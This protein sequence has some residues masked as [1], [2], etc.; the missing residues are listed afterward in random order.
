VHAVIRTFIIYHYLFTHY[1]SASRRCHGFRR[2]CQQRVRV[3]E[4]NVAWTSRPSNLQLATL[5]PPAHFFVHTPTATHP[6]PVLIFTF[7]SRLF[8]RRLSTIQHVQRPRRPHPQ[9][10]LLFLYHA[11]CTASIVA[12][13]N[14]SI[15]ATLDDKDAYSCLRTYCDNRRAQFCP[16]CLYL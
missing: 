2:G 3:N 15:P 12:H 4:M 6:T 10:P 13:N 1:T 7:I 5:S 8:F 14:G 11:S 16:C 9:L